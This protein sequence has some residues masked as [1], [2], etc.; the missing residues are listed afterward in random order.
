MD[1]GLNLHPLHWQVDS[2]PLR[3]QGSPRWA[4][5]GLTDPLSLAPCGSICT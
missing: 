4:L 1:Q 2:H 5:Y 3:H